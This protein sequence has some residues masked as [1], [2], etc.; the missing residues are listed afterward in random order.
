MSDASENLTGE[1][2]PFLRDV[3]GRSRPLTDADRVTEQ[4]LVDLG[5]PADEARAAVAEGRVPLVL[6]QR[7]LGEEPRYDIDELA[8][9]SGVAPEILTRVRVASG[10]E[11]PEKFTDTDLRWANHLNALLAVLPEEAVVRSARA[12]GTALATVARSDL[13]VVRDEVLLPM[14]Q[15]GADDLAVATGLAE[16]A[17]RLDELGRDILTITYGLQLEQQLGTELAAMLTRT[18]AAEV[19]IAVGFVDVVGWTSLSSRVDPAGLDDVLDAFEERV[20]A[21]TS[22]DKQVT[23]VKYLGDAVM[24]VAADPALLIGAMVE[25][26]TPVPELED[27]PLRGG[28]AAGG[29]LVREGDIYGPPVNRAARLT[30][31]ARPWSLLVDDDLADIVP[32]GLS[33]KRLRPVRLRGIGVRRPLSVRPRRAPNEDK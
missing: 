31:L 15:A 24:L 18:E 17:R 26:T 11:L 8:E 6:A 13:G 20:V 19:Q 4:A 3:L 25:L 9:R 30:D 12:R 27:V 5:L 7:V 22:P 32:E 1:L 21:V 23:V 28:M 2:P 33:T 16:T 29:G 14:R 10:L